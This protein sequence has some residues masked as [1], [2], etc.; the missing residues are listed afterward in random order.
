M[1]ID[2][3]LFDF[4]MSLVDTSH[5]IAYAMNRFAEMMGLRKVS[6]EE[7]LA[8]IG[9]PM[10]K[11]LS[12]LWKDAKPEWLEIYSQKC[13]PLEYERM[14]LFPGVSETLKALRDRGLKLGITSN[15]RSAKKAVTHL[16]LDGYF[17]VILG[18][19]DVNTPKPDPKII[20]KAIRIWGVDKDR[21]VYVGDTVIDMQTA[22][23][24]EVCGIGVTTGLYDEK[25]LI[26]AGASLVL[27]G[28]SRILDLC[29]P[30]KVM[31]KCLKK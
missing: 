4:D 2:A 26:E 19:E 21:V 15:R 28:V 9:I 8:T 16:G 7:V 5:A 3:I 27:P 18:L 25:S 6:Y 23:N 1:E 24:A 30:G 31:E 29:I 12:L 11:S 10:D 17:D 13:R 22:K 20:L 14:K